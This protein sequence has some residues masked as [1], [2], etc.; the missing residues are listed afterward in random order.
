M[1][2]SHV[3][4]NLALFLVILQTLLVDKKITRATLCWFRIYTV[5]GP[6]LALEYKKGYI[7]TMLKAGPS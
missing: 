4:N 5:N 3:R 6:S 1:K 7:V 2:N